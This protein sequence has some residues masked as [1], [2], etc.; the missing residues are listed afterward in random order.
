MNKYLATL[1]LVTLTLISF[2]QKLSSDGITV[3]LEGYEIVKKVVPIVGLYE[4][5]KGSFVVIRGKTIIA[6]YNFTAP[7]YSDNISEIKV[8]RDSIIEPVLQ[9]NISDE[10]FTYYKGTENEGK[11]AALKTKNDKKTILSGL[12]IWSKLIYNNRP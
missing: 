10:T 7:I 1:T 9:F 6:T 2:G 12:L 4:E 5:Y 8:M 3:K 11:E